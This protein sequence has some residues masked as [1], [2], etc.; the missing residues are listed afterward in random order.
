MDFEG[1]KTSQKSLFG[2]RDGRT[3]HL[4]FTSLVIASQQAFEFIGEIVFI[5]VLYNRIL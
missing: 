4:S 1:S 5:W 2:R 3:A